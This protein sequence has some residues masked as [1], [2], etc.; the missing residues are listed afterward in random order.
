MR[1]LAIF[2]VSIMTSLALAAPALADISHMP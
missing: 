1:R 2:V